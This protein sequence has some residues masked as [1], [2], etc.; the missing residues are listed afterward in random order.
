LRV[1]V[2]DDEPLARQ[3]LCALLGRRPEV[4]AIAEAVDGEAAL[5]ALRSTQ[6]D[7]LFLDVQMPGRGGLEVATALGAEG[8]PP[9]V[10][11]TAFD[12]YA[13]DAFAVS[14]VDYLLKPF[15]DERFDAAFERALERREGQ[16]AARAV[17][18]LRQLLSAEAER[19]PAHVAV[20]K[21]GRL[22]LLPL[23]EIDW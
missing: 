8:L 20:E 17:A 16:Q 12:R 18:G 3:R 22:T 11:V 4:A 13:V 15:E 5:D 23:A 1:L 21:G 19:P 14:A 6:F 10:F 2:V 7:L 9:V